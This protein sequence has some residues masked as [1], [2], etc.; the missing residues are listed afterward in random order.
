M[1]EDLSVD[2]T[3]KKN[4]RFR[5]HFLQKSE[6]VN[7]FKINHKRKFEIQKNISDENEVS[8]VNNLTSFF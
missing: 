7:I 5:T 8:D 6:F 2:E 1:I 3:L 4:Y